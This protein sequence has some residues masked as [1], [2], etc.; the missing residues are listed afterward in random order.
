MENVGSV[1]SLLIVLL[2]FKEEL[3]SHQGFILVSIATEF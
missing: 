3:L 1:E 2:D